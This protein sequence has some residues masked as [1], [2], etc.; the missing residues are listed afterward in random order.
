MKDIAAEYAYY[1]VCEKSVQQ[2]SSMSEY[3]TW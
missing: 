3:I 2:N 1:A